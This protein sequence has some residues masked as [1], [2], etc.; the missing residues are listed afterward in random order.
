MMRTIARLERE[1]VTRRAG[2]LYLIPLPLIALF[3]VV[4]IALGL[5]RT[6]AR[7]EPHRRI[8]PKWRDD[9]DRPSLRR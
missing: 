5:M 9:D 4:V 8:R 6:R 7:R 3:V 2:T 1:L